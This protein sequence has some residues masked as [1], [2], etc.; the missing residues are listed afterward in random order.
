MATGL[1]IALGAIALRLAGIAHA[2]SD[3]VTTRDFHIAFAVIGVVAL[4]ALLDFRRLAPDAAQALR[5]R[6]SS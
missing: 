3:V 5:R 2:G 6:A 4:T 1:G